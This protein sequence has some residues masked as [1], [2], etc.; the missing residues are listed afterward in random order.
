M[1]LA[2]GIT[3]TT[4]L[5]SIVMVELLPA[6]YGNVPRPYTMPKERVAA[7]DLANLA[8]QVSSFALD[9]NQQYPRSLDELK[10]K[11]IKK[12]SDDPWGRPYFYQPPSEPDLENF[13]LASAGA[14]GTWVTRDDVVR[15]PVD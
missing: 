7:G 8:T 13:G 6:L 9:H 10:P 11:Y 1:W 15:E 2:R 14:D 3:L 4:L 12:L 5:L